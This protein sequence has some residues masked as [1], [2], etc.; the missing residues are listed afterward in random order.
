MA[1]TPY[2]KKKRNAFTRQRKAVV[3]MIAE[4]KNKTETNYFSSL[5]KDV[6]AVIRFSSGKHTDPK[7][8]VAELGR[9][10][11]DGG[12]DQKSGDTAYCLIDADTNPDKDL[13][14]AEADKQAKKKSIRLIVSAPCFEVW[15]LCHYKKPGT[16]KTS[17]AVVQELKTFIP[18]YAKG[19][20][21]T[22]ELINEKASDAVSFA[23]QINSEC[24][25][26][27]YAPHTTSFSP[28][29][30]VVEVYED[31]MKKRK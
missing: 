29:T 28:S 26:K 4:G 31:L 3:F 5:G 2:Q 15:F 13:I 18:N 14:I 30:E 22:Y 12:F 9:F 6:G 1:V 25:S 7:N 16:F 10:M 23:R 19:S 11:N 27:G 8:M 21:G 20:T 17:E 24:K